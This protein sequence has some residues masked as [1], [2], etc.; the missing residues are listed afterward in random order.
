MR[1]ASC[2]HLVMQLGQCHNLLN[3]PDMRTQSGFHRRSDPQCLVNPRKVIVHMKQRDHR[4]VVLNLLD[5]CISQSSESR[6]FI[7]MLRFCRST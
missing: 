1:I 3:R 7:L 2:R 6:I 4:D 5:E